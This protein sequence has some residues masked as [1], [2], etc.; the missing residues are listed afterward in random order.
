MNFDVL[1]ESCLRLRGRLRHLKLRVRNFR[2]L[3]DSG[4]QLWYFNP[5]TLY[6]C[7][8]EIPGFLIGLGKFC[9]G[10]ERAGRLNHH[11]LLWQDIYKKKLLFLSP[12]CIVDEDAP[13]VVAYDDI[14]SGNLAKYLSLS[15]DLGG[16]IKTQVSCLFG[17]G[18]Q[19]TLAEIIN[20]CC[21]KS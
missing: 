13:F 8:K 14:V 11:P 4:C 2:N 1:N 10:V 19:K 12:S 6:K 17:L 15:N 16:D 20:A 5:I 9:K 18:S 7:K 3:S 21:E